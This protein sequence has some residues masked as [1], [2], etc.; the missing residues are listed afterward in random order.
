VQ[1]LLAVPKSDRG[2][3]RQGA[4]AQV[5]GRAVGANRK[6]LGGNQPGILQSDVQRLR[7]EDRRGQGRRESPRNDLRRAG[8]GIGDVL[9]NQSPRVLAENPQQ[10]QIGPRSDR[11]AVHGDFTTAQ[12]RQQLL[13]GGLLDQLGRAHPVADVED[14]AA[15]GVIELTQPM[16]EGLLHVRRAGGEPPAEGSD[17]FVKLLR[18]DR[19]EPFAHVAGFDVHGGEA[20]AISFRQQGEQRLEHGQ[21]LF[22]VRAHLAGRGVDENH[23]VARAGLDPGQSLGLQCQSEERVTARRLVLVDL[24][25]RDGFVGR[26]RQ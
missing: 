9:Q 21:C 25:R 14:R 13:H 23:V 6:C 2:I 22:A 16:S 12:L 24:G 1:C 19:Y 18:P 3:L 10:L 11:V 8:P 4:P 20:G 7:V 17:R 5:H 26:S 15:A